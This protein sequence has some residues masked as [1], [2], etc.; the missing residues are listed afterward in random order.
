MLSQIHSSTGLFQYRHRNALTV[1]DLVGLLLFGQLGSL[2]LLT[3][4]LL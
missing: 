3:V 1:N 2:V 4:K